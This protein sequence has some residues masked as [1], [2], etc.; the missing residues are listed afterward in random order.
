MAKRTL[1]VLLVAGMIAVVLIRGASRGWFGDDE[2]AGQVTRVARSEEKVA[3]TQ[4]DQAAT[5]AALGAPSA[6]QVLFGDF[7]VHTTFSFDAFLLNLPMSG[8]GG[9]YP[10][11]D[12]C[13]FARYCSALDFWSINDHAEGLT[14]RLWEET[15]ESVRQCNDVAGDPSN[16][17][18]VTYLGWEW[19]HIGST[20][21]NHY[22][23]KNVVVLG[24][25]D[26]EIPARPIASRAAGTSNIGPTT[27]QRLA[28]A[29]A[30][31]QRG[32]EFNRMISA[33]GKTPPCPDNIPVRDL[34]SDCRES[35]ATPDVL[36]AKL[37]D[38]GLPAIVIPHGTAWGLY[39][40]AGSDWR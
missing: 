38:W 37:D 14:P 9:S 24:T 16:P 39:T 28:L 23:H 20:P 22:G 30:N 17:D 33:I 3:S 8:G 32:I 12:A 6:K 13:D 31:G 1:I 26:D 10:P 34:P 27:L 40:P 2:T 15:I 25:D 18:L 35:A 29:A 7:H 5:L 11:S 4:A 36:F 21:R 19:S